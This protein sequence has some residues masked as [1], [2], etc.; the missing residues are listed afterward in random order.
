MVSDWFSVVTR[1]RSRGYGK[2]TR[3]H[4]DFAYNTKMQQWRNG[5][6]PPFAAE[7]ISRWE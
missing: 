1:D 2:D 5:Y 3:K 4:R 6:A 7:I